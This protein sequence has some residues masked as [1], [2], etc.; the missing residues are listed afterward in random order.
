MQKC[1]RPDFKPLKVAITFELFWM[2]TFRVNM[3]DSTQVELM[4]PQLQRQ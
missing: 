3:E 2:L 1:Y 4:Q